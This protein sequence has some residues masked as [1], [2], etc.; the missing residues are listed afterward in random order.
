MRIRFGLILKITVWTKSYIIKQM[1]RIYSTR[2][3]ARKTSI[4]R[5][6]IAYFYLSHLL[7]GYVPEKF[8]ESRKLQN[9]REGQRP[10]CPCTRRI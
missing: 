5:I 6:F 7:E 3:E 4:N 2:N 10:R 9:S 1:H 8:Q